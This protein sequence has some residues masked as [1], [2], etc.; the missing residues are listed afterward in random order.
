MARRV[1][2]EHFCQ[3]EQDLK[4]R[5]KQKGSGLKIIQSFF[6]EESRLPELNRRPTDY[7]S[8]ALPTE[9]SRRKNSLRQVATTQHHV[10][11]ESIPFR[12]DA[13]THAEP[14]GIVLTKGK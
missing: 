6:E 11:G 1:K 9:L 14:G 4:R 7:E 3:V 12:C 13:Q 10:K 5:E 8:V 2:S